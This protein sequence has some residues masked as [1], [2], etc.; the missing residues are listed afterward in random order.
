MK[1]AYLSTL[2][3]KVNQFESAAFKTDMEE[4]GLMV[5]RDVTEADIVVINTCAVTNK[6]SAQSR[7][8]IRRAARRNPGAE[9]IVTGCHAQ[10]AADEL[11]S[12]PD[13][14]QERLQIIGNEFKQSLVSTILD[15]QSE[16][17]KTVCGDM[18]EVTDI[19]RLSVKRFGGRT[20]AFL[21]VQDGCNSF[22]SYCI[23]P[24][25][26]GRSRSLPYDEVVSQARTYGQAGHLE[27]VITGIHVGQYGTDLHAGIDI[28][29]LMKRLCLALPSIRFRLSSIEPLEISV[30]LLT[31]MKE[32][33][34]FMPHLHIPLQSG[35]NDILTRMNR[36][37]NQ[38]QFVDVIETCNEIVPEAAI[39]IDVLVGFPGETTAQFINTRNL[40][41]RI[42]CTYLHVFPYSNRPGTKAATFGNQLNRHEKH[43]RVDILRNLGQAKKTDFYRQFIGTKR[44]ALL[45]TERA[46]DGRLKGFTDNYIPILA[47]GDDQLMNHVVLVD[48]QTLANTS[49]NGRIISDI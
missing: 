3:C 10:L 13:I 22:C 34:N 36:R 29:E 6:A 27:I 42:N 32:L 44:P 16:P 30:E 17:C 33:D 1:K 26:R 25:T 43:E 24:F 45:E 49:V 7:R 40:L 9:I 41:E 31:L 48:L 20:R 14:D 2:G 18:N 38:D 35:D 21:R 28:C 37:Y 23:V 39:G 47:K 19:S 8:E 15:K 46:I 4:R 11:K 12:L 5:T